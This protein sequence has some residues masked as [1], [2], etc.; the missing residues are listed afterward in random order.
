MDSGVKLADATVCAL[1][2]AAAVE[3]VFAEANQLTYF[4]EGAVVYQVTAV[5]ALP[6]DTPCGT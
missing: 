3:A 4:T 1:V 2:P 5:A 6:G